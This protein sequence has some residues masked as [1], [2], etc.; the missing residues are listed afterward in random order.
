MSSATSPPPQQST[1]ANQYRAFNR[2]PPRRP[3]FV[4]SE[5]IGS[6]ADY[7]EAPPIHSPLR[8]NYVHRPDHQHF[9]HQPRRPSIVDPYHRLELPYFSGLDPHVWVSKCTELF[10]LYSVPE[11]QKV[12]LGLHYLDGRA[13]TWFEGWSFWRFPL[14]WG[15]FVGGLLLRFGSQVQMTV[16][17]ACNQLQQPLVLPSLISEGTGFVGDSQVHTQATS[18]LF[19]L[20]GSAPCL[21]FLDTPSTRLPFVR[22]VLC[23]SQTTK[24]YASSPN[25]KMISAVYMDKILTVEESAFIFGDPCPTEFV[26]GIFGCTIEPGN[27]NWS[28]GFHVFPTFYGIL[29]HFHGSRN[30]DDFKGPYKDCVLPL[31]EGFVRVPKV[32]LSA[33]WIGKDDSGELNCERKCRKKCSYSAYTE[34]DAA[35]K[36]KGCLL[37]YGE[38][39]DTMYFPASSQDLYVRVEAEEFATFQGGFNDSLELK[40]SILLSS[41]GS[42]GLLVIVFAF[43]W[44]RKRQIKSVKKRRTR[45]LFHPIDG[46]DVASVPGLNAQGLPTFAVTKL[47]CERVDHT[48][49]SLDALWNWALICLCYSWV[50]HIRVALVSNQSLCFLAAELIEMFCQTLPLPEGWNAQESCCPNPKTKTVVKLPEIG[51]AISAPTDTARTKAAVQLSAICEQGKPDCDASAFAVDASATRG[52]N[53]GSLALLQG[54]ASY[55]SILNTA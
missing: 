24:T 14:L 30:H 29:R 5:Q 9:R 13:R 3:F 4:V 35:L 50:V 37:W 21:N 54:A 23:G 20:L 18:S 43:F 27:A 46:G 49:R 38:L 45:Y 11:D 12:D 16:V 6:M 36:D 39:V 53:L 2:P 40:L 26:F 41:M 33:V 25:Q 34:I 17:A 28:Y 42:A 51:Q 19:P 48:E 52:S 8:P 7:Q 44:L 1:G 31:G 32:K 15:D 22:K 10:L 55:F 47:A